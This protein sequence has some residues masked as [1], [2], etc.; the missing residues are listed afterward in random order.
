MRE[1]HEVN[2]FQSNIR[3][4]VGYGADVT[5]LS[6]S[7]SKAINSVFHLRDASAARGLPVCLDGVGAARPVLG[8]LWAVRCPAG[9]A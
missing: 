7:T 1:N 4:I 6:P 3:Y 2:A 5:L 8:C 9:G